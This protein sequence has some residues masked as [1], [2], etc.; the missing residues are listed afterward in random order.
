MK[1]PSI[2]D[3]IF[4]GKRVVLRGDIDVMG[5]SD[6]RL[7]LLLPAIKGLFKKG[8]DKI[9]LIGHIG[10]PNGKKVEKLSTKHLKTWFKKRIKSRNFV[11]YENLRFWREEKENDSVFAKK[12][13]RL[14]DIFVNESFAT[15][16]RRHASVVGLP[17]LLPTAFGPRFIEEINNLD[18]IINSPKKPVI[19]LI[20]G[21][22]RDKLDYLAGLKK[23]ANK[24]L[25]AGRLP[26]YLD[27]DFQEKGVVVA[28]LMPDK[29]DITV[30]SIEKFT[31]ILSFAGTI[32]VA[33]PVGKF[34]EKG[35]LLGTKRVFESVV[36]SSAAKMAGGGDTEA[37]ISKLG[38]NNKFDWIST[39]GGASLEY[40][41]KRT[42]PAIEAL[43]D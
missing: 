20:G 8:A 40:L 9:T 6:T 12:L 28:R 22:K 7:E 19:I 26:D 29:E 4:S 35:H 39:G 43:V 1:L 3:F 11:L 14:G 15:S 23:I 2:D 42:L 27:E 31:S 18:M 10:R 36:Q 32:F 17:K 5:D 33:G 34:E 37:A 24:V 16:H 41:T 21:V 25:V 30:N 38:L 13:A